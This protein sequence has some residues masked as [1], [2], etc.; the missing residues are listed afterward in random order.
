MGKWTSLSNGA[1][2]R[3]CSSIH[4]SCACMQRLG[5]GACRRVC[6]APKY[7]CPS[8]LAR[9][10][11]NR[12][13]LVC[14]IA[15]PVSL[16]LLVVLRLAQQARRR[17]CRASC[18]AWPSRTPTAGELR[19]GS[20]PGLALP[21]QMAGMPLSVSPAAPAALDAGAA[22]QCTVVPPG[23]PTGAAAVRCHS[24]CSTIPGWTG[25]SDPKI[26]LDG[27]EMVRCCVLVGGSE[28]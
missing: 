21:G 11:A 18:R 19:S 14:Y 2:N 8:M 25:C 6:R 15:C 3:A 28:L 22:E 17:R 12:L 16:I 26:E 24:M 20:F 9:H 13:Q 7:G 27:C 4:F 1:L 5:W 23:D 10:R